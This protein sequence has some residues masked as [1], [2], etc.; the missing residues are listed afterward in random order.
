MKDNK[1]E[2]GDVLYTISNYGGMRKFVIDRVTKTQAIAG[3]TKFKIEGSGTGNFYII[4]ADRWA[5]SWA[6]IATPEL[7]LRYKMIGL[8]SF[9][10]SEIDLIQNCDVDELQAIYN[11]LKKYKK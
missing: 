10:K 1:I 4:G 5:P 2:P 3:I 11:I 9:I 6:K 7:D 8:S